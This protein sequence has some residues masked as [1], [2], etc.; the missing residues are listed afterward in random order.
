MSALFL[1]LLLLT[2]PARAWELDSERVTLRPAPE[3]VLPMPEGV[4][5]PAP[6]GAALESSQYLLVDD[7][8]RVEG[9]QVTRYSHTTYRIVTREGLDGM[10]RLEVEFDPDYGSV[11][12]HHL[13]VWRDGAW[14]DRL[15]GSRAALIQKEAALWQHLF[16]G[17]QTLVVV[18]PD[19]RVGD[20]VSCAYSLSGLNPVFQ[21]HYSE[22]WDMAWGVPAARRHLRLL[23]QEQEPLYLKAHGIGGPV[24]RSRAEGWQEARWDLRDVPALPDIYEAPAGFDPYPWVQAS[25]F[26]QWS[27]VADWALGVYASA[28]APGPEVRALAERLADEAEDQQDFVADALRWVQDEVRYFGIEVGANSHAPHRPSTVLARRYGDCKDKSLLLVSLLRARGI[29]AQLALVNGRLLG[30]VEEALPSPTAFDHVIVRAQLEGR[31]FWMDPTESHQGGPVRASWTAPFGK[32]LLVAPGQLELAELPLSVL[33]Q[34]RTEIRHSYDLAADPDLPAMGVSTLFEGRR[35][36][37]M[38]R[39][40]ADISP[41]RLQDQYLDHYAQLGYRADLDAPF[42]IRD[43]RERNALIL[44]ESYRLQGAWTEDAKGA[45]QLVLPSLGIF[46]WLPA[47]AAGRRAP[48]ALPQGLDETE[49]LWIKVPKGW[50]LEHLEGEIENPWFDF[51][52]TSVPGADT[53]TLEYRLQVSADRVRPAEMG[54]YQ[55]ELN[56]LQSLE[57]YALQRPQEKRW[58]TM[59]LLRRIGGWLKDLLVYALVAAAV[60]LAVPISIGGAVLLVW[61]GLP[62]LV[63][64]KEVD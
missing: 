43:D 64:K 6:V 30:A 38:R 29:S 60:I 57:G 10:S 45:Q 22:T 32:A 50:E 44:E 16:D 56:R 34:G 17:T 7:Q 47:P 62:S 2:L 20:V 58:L 35:A 42:V 23:W 14:H 26:H 53:I 13:R 24:L 5:R 28:E 49:R 36:E 18:M 52:V 63:P 59:D 46:T 8:V 27:Q 31:D 4:D 33:P 9:D 61:I 25:D 1:I 55:A 3:W 48:L 40:L 21:G 12:L 39:M 19:V 54:D 51:R 37:Q 15:E 41:Q 11:A